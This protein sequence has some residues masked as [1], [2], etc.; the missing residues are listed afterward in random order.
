MAFYNC[1]YLLTQLE[2][3]LTLSVT[4]LTVAHHRAETEVLLALVV[5]IETRL[6]NSE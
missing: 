1:F 2:V 4:I 6:V 5:K 3:E